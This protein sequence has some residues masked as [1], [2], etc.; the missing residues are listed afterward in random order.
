[1]LGR[2]SMKGRI[3]SSVRLLFARDSEGGAFWSRDWMVRVPMSVEPR[4]RCWRVEGWFFTMRRPLASFS[5][6]WERSRDLS[7][8]EGSCCARAFMV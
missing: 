1:M 8:V 5:S 4:L 7:S 6:V 3:C 2:F